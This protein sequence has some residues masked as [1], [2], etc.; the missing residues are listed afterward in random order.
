M[1]WSKVI[2]IGVVLVAIGFAGGYFYGENKTRKAM[3]PEHL[4][5]DKYKVVRTPGGMLEVSTLIKHE[6]LAWQTSW[7]CPLG[8]CNGLPNSL[9]QISAVAH[10]TY[11]VSLAEYW[12]LEKMSDQPLKYR[13]KAPK[14]EPKLP[15]AVSLSSIRVN[16]DNGNLIS[17]SGPDQQKMQ[18]YLQQA[19]A[20]RAMDPSYIKVQSN[21]AVKTIEEFARKWM[22]ADGEKISDK[23]VIEVIL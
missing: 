5:G 22:S 6:T 12:I 4:V 10:Y 11:R 13:L 23:A 16:K 15:V 20:Q 14:L 1:A 19:L 9:S 2:P 8:L 7:T 18:N 21:D 17:P 3:A